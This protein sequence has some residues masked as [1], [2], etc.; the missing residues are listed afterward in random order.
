MKPCTI[1]GA[2]YWPRTKRSKA[3]SSTCQRELSRR[4]CQRWSD[5]YRWR[6]PWRV[7]AADRRASVGILFASGLPALILLGSL[8]PETANYGH[9]KIGLMF[10]A[11][12]A[13]LAAAQG[14]AQTPPNPT[15]NAYTLARANGVR[16]RL[17]VSIVGNQVTVSI[18]KPYTPLMVSW[19]SSTLTASA[20]AQMTQTPGVGTAPPVVKVSLTNVH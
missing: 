10:A 3:C 14:L 15:H 16:G 8:G 4:N 18:T 19:A 9:Q 17:A 6:E 13:A 20:T 11:E 7:S 5:R 1:C 2:R 12:T